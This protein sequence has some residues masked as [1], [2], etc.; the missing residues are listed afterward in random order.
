MRIGMKV[1]L[2]CTS[3]GIFLGFA[4]YANSAQPSGPGALVA[5]Q[6]IKVQVLSA[7][8]DGKISQKER[9]NIL[10][11]AQ[12][13]LSAQEYVGLVQTINRLSPPESGTPEDIGYAP[14]VDKQLMAKFP[15]GDLPW[16][17]KLS[18]SNGVL[19]QG[20]VKNVTPN[21]EYVVREII[22]KQTIVKETVPQQSVVKTTTFKQPVVHKTTSKQIVTKTASPKQS[23]AKVT[24]QKQAVAKATTTKQ[25]IAKT[26]AVKQTAAK[27]TKT[28]PSSK[29]VILPPP[30]VQKIAKQPKPSTVSK[31]QISVP[32]IEM[33]A[34]PLPPAVS[35][36]SP[37]AA[38]E[39]P[40]P[41]K[42]TNN[43][44]KRDPAVEQAN[45][46]QP[47]EMWSKGERSAI[48]NVYTDYNVPVL[49]TPA[50][51]MLYDGNTVIIKAAF[52]QPLQPDETRRG[53]ISQ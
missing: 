50:A 34:P 44:I 51:A 24:T 10:E 7:M 14:I 32:K 36:Q 15:A 27:T 2:L 3:V 40:V 45:L 6:R 16:I 26:V 37:S 1:M 42:T 8:D 47:A 13:I 31:V 41:L 38:V 48:R 22:T 53:I 46:Q 9:R 21:R 29:V 33:P 28:N 52:D 4:S 23:V 25:S 20:L 18:K 19:K 43:Q 39:R 30:P 11:N 17:D 5:K 35:P 49:N 12:D